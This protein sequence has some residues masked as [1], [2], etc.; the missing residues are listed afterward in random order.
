MLQD[1]CIWLHCTVFNPIKTILWTLHSDT[2]LLFVM[3][4]FILLHLDLWH[5]RHGLSFALICFLNESLHPKTGVCVSWLFRYT[6]CHLND[7][8]GVKL[9][10]SPVSPTDRCH[11]T[12]WLTC[13]LVKCDTH[14]EDKRFVAEEKKRK[15]KTDVKMLEQ[16]GRLPPEPQG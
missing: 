13:L 10:S 8:Q 5:F 15:E 12:I 14:W 4:R 6:V 3:I 7:G 2:T 11:F 16:T 1:N 9:N